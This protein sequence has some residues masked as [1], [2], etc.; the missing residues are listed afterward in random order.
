M[1]FAVHEL[2]PEIV[3]HHGNPLRPLPGTQ[4][5]HY[6]LFPGLYCNPFPYVTIY[7]VAVWYGLVEGGVFKK[8]FQNLYIGGSSGRDF[9]SLPKLCPQELFWKAILLRMLWVSRPTN[10]IDFYCTP[11]FQLADG[12]VQLFQ[13]Q[14]TCFA[15]ANSVT[16]DVFRLSS[17]AVSLLAISQP[18]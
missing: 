18:T 11:F 8:S 14:G 13:K 15:W 1:G 3:G 16:L 7:T 9:R 17:F 2:K 12:P 5:L 4:T 10:A 6:S